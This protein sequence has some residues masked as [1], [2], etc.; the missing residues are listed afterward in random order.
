MYKIFKKI[1]HLF[2]KLKERK[3]KN[4]LK[5]LFFNN[6]S[7]RLVVV[8]SAFSPHPTYNYLR[9][10]KGFK[11][12]DKLFILD[13][14]GYKGS[15]YWFENGSDMPLNLTL[16]LISKITGSRQY[17]ELITM[18]SSKGGTCAI[19]YGLHF[20]A[21]H[22]YAGACQYYVGNYLNNNT[23]LP[24]M[25][26][27]LG[28]D[29]TQEDVAKLNAMMETQLSSH[30]GSR[31]MIHLLYSKNEHTYN[32]HVVF[33]LNDLKN[34]MIPYMEKVEDFSNHSDVGKFFSLFVKEELS[35]L[36]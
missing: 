32:E 33:L 22:I 6:H 16:E 27:M 26:A 11:H 14:F 36:K 18:G 3:Y 7:N 13:D 10:L 9:T 19:Y 20:N 12:F 17:D 24:I 25:K 8:F 1:F 23:N 15:Y 28:D 4:R 31:S 5:Y 2:L 35:K 21:S 30:K 29:F 34:Y